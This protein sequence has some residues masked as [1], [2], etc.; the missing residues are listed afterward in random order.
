MET[1]LTI[2]GLPAAGKSYLY[3]VLKEQKI[4]RDVC[5][6]PEPVEKFKKFQSFNPLLEYYKNPINNAGFCQIY[7]LNTV[8]DLHR[9][10]LLTNVTKSISERNIYST[11]IFTDVQHKLGYLSAFQHEYINDLIKEKIVDILPSS[12]PFACNKLVYLDSDIDVC[13]DRIKNNRF[14]ES[15]MND[16]ENY[17]RELQRG[18]EN[19][20]DVF[21]EEHGAENSLKLT[22][23]TPVTKMV[24]AVVG[25]LYN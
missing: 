22:D 17:L 25:L 4:C 13:L 2:E 10:K 11:K 1:L 18:L 3:N 12:F 19:Y 20:F 15:S 24:D 7:F 5:F 23:Q 14:E 8:S 9:E 16:L 6:I 21:V